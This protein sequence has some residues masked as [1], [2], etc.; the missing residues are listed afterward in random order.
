MR[1]CPIEDGNGAELILAYGAGTL[2]PQTEAAFQ[3]HMRSCE[4]CREL[5]A[6]QRE[7]WSALDHWTPV[8]VSS[9]F[10]EKLFRRIAQEEQSTWWQRLWSANWSWRPALPVA[11]AC[12]VLA[13]V[14]LLKA[15]ESAPQPVTPVQPKVQIE[16]VERALDDME[17]L[18]SLGVE[19][20]AEQ[21][22]STERI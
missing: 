8:P 3:Q 7:V 5:A 1:E 12:A 17:L 15:P 10:D 19:V 2:D 11:A 4:S 13:A 14:V 18:K 20:P 9:D 22:K 6:A 16:Q 21:V